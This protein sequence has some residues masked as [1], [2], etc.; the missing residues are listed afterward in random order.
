MLYGWLE[1]NSPSALCNFLLSNSNYARLIQVTTLYGIQET[2]GHSYC[3][4]LKSGGKE[5]CDF[6]LFL[7]IKYLLLMAYIKFTVYYI[8]LLERSE[9]TE[10]NVW[11][12]Y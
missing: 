11:I 5:I 4:F 1:S 2:N 12:Q 7:F 6:S 3:K 9:I 10:A 8:L